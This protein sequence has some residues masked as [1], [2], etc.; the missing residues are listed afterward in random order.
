MLVDVNYLGN[1]S[2]SARVRCSTNEC[3]V[4]VKLEEYTED[5]LKQLKQ[6]AIDKYNEV[7]NLESIKGF[8]REEIFQTGNKIELRNGARYEIFET[9]YLNTSLGNAQTEIWY[10]ALSLTSEVA[11]TALDCQWDK[12]GFYGVSAFMDIVRVYDKDNNIKAERSCLN[13]FTSKKLILSED[14]F[15]NGKCPYKKR[16]GIL[17][18]E[19]V[20]KIGKVV[21]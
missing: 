14:E 8:T 1:D 13:P 9:D 2:Y 19:K 6:L 16:K 5:N 7:A 17:D 11:H 15:W 4:R 3:E 12:Y 20:S 18:K 10:V 21:G